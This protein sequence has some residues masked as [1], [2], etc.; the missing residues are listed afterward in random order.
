MITRKRK[1]YKFAKFHNSSLCFEFDEWEQQ[2]V[3]CVEVGAG[4]AMFFVELATLYPGKQFVA[5]DVKADRLQ[6][7]AYEAEARGLRNIRFLRARADQLMECFSPESLHS[8]WITFADPYPKKRAAG[9]RL[10]HS[11]FLDIYSSLLRP[12]GA[13]YIKHDNPDF[14]CWT[15]KQLVARQWHIKELTFDLH[16]SQL[17]DDYKLQTTYETR[18]L[19]EGSVTHFVKAT[20]S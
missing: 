15:L 13:V 2:S 12:G 11:T 8:I 10:T 1:Q 14:F 3:D 20:A 17:S 5:L 9:R 6:K 16:E 18:W 4:T 19:G 7:G